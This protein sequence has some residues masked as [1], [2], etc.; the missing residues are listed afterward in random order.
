MTLTLQNCHF[1][2]DLG[3]GPSAGMA[4][5]ILLVGPLGAVILVLVADRSLLGPGESKTGTAPGG[6]P[7]GPITQMEGPCSPVLGLLLPHS[8]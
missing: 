5:L 7:S 2:F 1:P 8:G 4:N 3:L 6:V